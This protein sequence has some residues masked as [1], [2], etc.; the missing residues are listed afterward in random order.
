[1][2]AAGYTIAGM[3][4]FVCLILL[5]APLLGQA[6]SASVV[7]RVVD[8]S[9]A[10][11]PGVAVKISNLD[12]NQTYRGSSNGSGDY[13]VLYLI[14]GRYSLEALAQGFRDYKRSEF[15]LQVDQELRL[16]IKLEVGATTETVTVTD[17]PTA[18]NT[19]SGM[20]GDVT[21]N[22]E[23]TEMPLNGRNFTD[24]AYLTGGVLPPGS[25]ADGQFAV[26]GARAD[27]VSS[28]VDGM[29]NTQRRNTAFVVG[30][31][32]DSIQEFKMITSGFSAEYGRFAGGVLSVAT[33]SGANRVRG[34]LYEFLRNSALNARNYF[35]AGKSKVIQNQF[36]STVSGPVFIPK[37]Y[38]GHDHTFFLV[39]W[40]SLRQI[41]GSTQRGI[42]PQAQ[43]LQGNWSRAAGGNP[44]GISTPKRPASL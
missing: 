24:L 9:G 1:M 30:P 4:R 25:G 31:S 13:T 36:G 35:D 27:N 40:E 39:S 8:A 23:I 7:G 5:A 22:A 14:P 26:N 44:S 11:V 17:T 15:T 3:L 41:S 28:L 21:T 42:V 18:L 33:K 6:P 20:R 37:V 2:G 29:N 16:D 34:S 12:T 19:E 32:V 43:M 10:V 38:N